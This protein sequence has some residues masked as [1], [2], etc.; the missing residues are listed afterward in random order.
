M[1][2]GRRLASCGQMLS[3]SKLIWRVKT[4]C[5]V[6]FDS[7][8]ACPCFQGQTKDVTVYRFISAG[9]VEEKM[10]EKQVHKDGIKRVVLSNAGATARYFD[11]AE[12]KDLF[13]LVPDGV[14]ATLEKFNKKLDN[15][16]AE[17]TGKPSF[18]TK[19]PMVIGVASHDVLYSTIEIDVDDETPF[20]RLPYQKTS[21]GKGATPLNAQIDLTL[22]D[23]SLE[24]ALDL[25]PLGGGFNR[26]KQKI[27]G[28]KD[29]TRNNVENVLRDT[30]SLINIQKYG[31]ALDVLLSSIEGDFALIK[32]DDK[33]SIHAKVAQ[34]AGALGWLPGAAVSSVPFL[35]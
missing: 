7:P 22:D 23:S 28:A 10:Y 8:H 33:L 5:F 31:E 25:K 34:V 3:N 15:N 9:T 19:H 27:E 18:L 1:E 16:A 11:H 14:S 30:D 13:K 17:S 20:S 6:L 29:A 12:L 35:S 4:N 32:G 2:S 21:M 26:I 24:V